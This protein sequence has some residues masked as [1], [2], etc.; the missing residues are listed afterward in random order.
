MSSHLNVEIY[1]KK[2]KKAKDTFQKFVRV[3]QINR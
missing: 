1:K 2:K 3:V